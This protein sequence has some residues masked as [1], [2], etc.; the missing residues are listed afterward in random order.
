[1]PKIVVQPNPGNI[2]QPKPDIAV[3]PKPYIVEPSIPAIG[4]QPKPHIVEPP[5]HKPVEPPTPHIVEPPKPKL[6]EPPKPKPVEPPKPK[7]VE[8][9]VIEKPQPLSEERLNK[10]IKLSNMYGETKDGHFVGPTVVMSEG[11]PIGTAVFDDE[12]RT[13]RYSLTDKSVLY[14]GRAVFSWETKKDTVDQQP[15][16]VDALSEPPRL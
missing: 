6:V 4:V 16:S 11:K 2:V 12:G 3:Q 9:P 15:D 10:L 13:F 7:P 5:I 1:M 14:E 8:P